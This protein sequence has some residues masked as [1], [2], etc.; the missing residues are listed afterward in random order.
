MLHRVA[1]DPP[2]IA[3]FADSTDGH[4]NALEKRLIAQGAS[5]CRASLA[6]CSF[7]TGAP[8]GI[9]IPGLDGLPDAALVR[10]IAAGSFEAVTRRL[11]ILHGLR[12]AGVLVWNDARAIER[13][14]DKSTTTFL[15]A[16][17][18]IAVPPTWTVERREEAEAILRREEVHGPLVLKPLFG[19]QGKGLRLIRKAD[20]LPP[21]EDVAGV[22]YLQRFM[23]LHR[24]GYRDH[25]VFVVAGRAVAAMSRRSDHWITNI[26]QGGEPEPV[27][28][29]DELC[30]IAVRA[31]AAVGAD[32]AGV[33]ILRHAPGEAVVLE[34]NSMPAWS[35]LRRVA[36]IDIPLEITRALIEAIRARAAR[37][38]AG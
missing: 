25:R 9:R 10:T 18:G 29:D 19:A 23:G 36:D 20:E 1:L 13:C 7:D 31:S 34:V 33:D 30:D 38:I 17:N 5:V 26:K 35:G 28:P 32:F 12:E 16:H 21:P 8:G 24:D 6:A 3:L 22:Y 37:R 2:R 4:A 11:G 15:L 27:T 14:V